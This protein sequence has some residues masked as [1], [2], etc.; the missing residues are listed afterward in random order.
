MHAPDSLEANI[1]YLTGE[2]SHAF[3]QALT[4]GFKREKVPLTVEQFA[5]LAVLFYQNGVNQKELGTLLSRDKTTMARVISIM[6]KNKLVLRRTDKKD[7]R[8]NLLYLTK[9]GERLQKSGIKVAGILYQQ[10]IKDIGE[11]DLKRGREVLIKMMKNISPLG[12]TSKM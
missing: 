11:D 5:V 2:F 3:H 4:H 7:G 8:A 9:R 12:A 1:I 6:I 10:A